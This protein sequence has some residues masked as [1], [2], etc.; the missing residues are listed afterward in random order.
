MLP[1]FYKRNE[2]IGPLSSRPLE[3]CPIILWVSCKNTPAVLRYEWGHSSFRTNKHNGPG[4]LGFPLPLSWFLLAGSHGNLACDEWT[5]VLL[6]N[7]DEQRETHLRFSVGFSLM[8]MGR[9]LADSH[10]HLL[11][12]HL[13]NS[14]FSPAKL[15]Y[16]QMLK[17]KICQCH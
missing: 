1:A 6:A 10:L 13:W 3:K 16:P 8:N 15:S 5:F 17:K 4:E 9:A 11:C 14:I 2:E 12:F 7:K